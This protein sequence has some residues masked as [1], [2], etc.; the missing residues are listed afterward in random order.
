MTKTA[1]FSAF[2]NPKSPH[3]RLVNDT[4]A[5]ATIVSV[6]FIALETIP[7]WSE[8]KIF[9]IIEWASVVLFSLEYVLRVW[10]DPNRWRYI[11]SFL[12]IVDLVAILPS[13]LGIGNLTFLKSVRI[14]R[15]LRFLRLLRL[16]KLSRIGIGKK[17]KEANIFGLNIT[18]YFVA[19]ISVLFIFGL[20]LHI[21]NLEGEEYW[22]IP[23]GMLWALLEFLS[24]DN[25][26]ELSGTLGV[27]MK[28]LAS[29]F[30]MV[31]F[32]LLVGV[33]GQLLNNFLLG[34]EDSKKK[35]DKK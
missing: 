4:L 21:A 5:L 22:S 6:I 29:F 7:A 10:S 35:T 8:Y 34:K 31:M 30:G 1:I 9:R 19:L 16:A 26:R 11:F 24:V 12:G 25:F 13:L 18:I 15:I 27:V 32:G 3:Y 14:V 17:D 33:T 2:E 23:E 28:V 20:V